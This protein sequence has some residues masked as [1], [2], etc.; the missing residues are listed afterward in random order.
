MA[1]D[2]EISPDDN[3]IRVDDNEIRTDDDEIRA[4]D[5]E[6]RADDD[7]RHPDYDERRPE[8]N[9]PQRRIN[10]PQ[11]RIDDLSREDDERKSGID[12]RSLADNQR[13][14]KFVIRSP[15]FFISDER[16]AE[17]RL[18]LCRV[19][20]EHIGKGKLRAFDFHLGSVAPRV[21]QAIESFAH[22][23]QVKADDMRCD[24]NRWDA[25]L[26]REAAHGGLAHLKDSG[27]LARG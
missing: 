20:S 22:G 10:D 13:R 12:E 8:D 18:M 1:D 27:E 17:L 26:L 5:D 7:E 15:A 25:P 19:I 4:D 9:D 24:A 6:I 16:L 23:F 2:N 14:R 11:R 3:E 21:F